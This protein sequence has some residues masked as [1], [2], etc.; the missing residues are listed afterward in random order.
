MRHRALGVVALV[1][2][3]A[4][5]V[6]A[7][8]AKE[9]QANVV[10]MQSQLTPGEPVP[11]VLELSVLGATG[12][13]SE[14]PIAVAQDVAVVVSGDERTERFPAVELR[15]GRYGT[16]IVFPESGDWS[17]R[18]T[19]GE[20]APILLGKGAVRIDEESSASRRRLSEL[21]L[22]LAGAALLAF[23]HV[24]SRPT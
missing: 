12:E 19:V 13:A 11:L 10:S 4:V 22:M 5:L 3:L 14:H 15:A 7:A 16:E 8:Q 18:V 1:V 21:P 23:L 17:L 6:P 9:L 2:A 24:R 20:D